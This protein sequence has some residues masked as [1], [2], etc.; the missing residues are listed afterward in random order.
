MSVPIVSVIIPV[1]N[2][3][4]YLR[5]TIEAVQRQT[6]SNIDIWVVNDGS[7]D[8][9]AAIV[10]EMMKLDPRLRLINK[11]NTGVSDTRNQGIAKSTGTYVAVL[12]ADDIWEADNLEKKLK[13]MEQTGKP[14]AYSNLSFIDGEGQPI[15]KEE[16]IIA[17]DFY[18][19]LLKWEI[20]VPGPCSNVIASRSLLGTDVWFDVNIP[21]PADRDICIQLARKAEPVFVNEKLWR[22]RIH[23]QSMTAVNKRVATEMALMYQKYINENYFPDRQTRRIALSKVYLI[24]A[25][26]CIRFTKERGKGIRYMAKSFWANPVIFIRTMLGKIRHRT[27]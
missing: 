2:G 7:K 19:N 24:I 13:A 15:Q 1:Y 12:D 6:I 20:V 5:E 4:K 25:G 26:I 11:E 27:V 21:C 16:P 22:Y 3:E 18:K 9:T 8:N 17:S 23:G 10:E 14:W